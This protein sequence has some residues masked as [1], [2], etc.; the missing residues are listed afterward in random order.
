[1]ISSALCFHIQTFI[2][3]LYFIPAVELYLMKFSYMMII[4]FGSQWQLRLTFVVSVE[5]EFKAV[6]MGN[7]P[8]PFLLLFS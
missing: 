3:P 1:M 2:G 8:F 5:L 4:I 6:C 7:S